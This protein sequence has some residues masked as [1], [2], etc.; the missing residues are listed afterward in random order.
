ME[1]SGNRQNHI[2]GMNKKDIFY[3]KKS[4][5]SLKNSY[6]ILRNL[7]NL[8]S[9]SLSLIIDYFK[10]FSFLSPFFIKCKLSNNFPKE[11]CAEFK[12][13]MINRMF[14]DVSSQ[15]LKY[16]HRKTNEEYNFLQL[17]KIQVN[18]VA[19]NKRMRNLYHPRSWFI[20]SIF[21]NTN[22]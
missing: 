4:F 2:F 5:Y 7:E 3:A 14:G 11:T 12:N 10:Q 17:H 9:I 20:L 6:Y 16:Y 8:D 13:I 21:L 22:I 18:I 15:L 19:T 1:E